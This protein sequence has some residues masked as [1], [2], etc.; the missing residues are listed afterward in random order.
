MSGARRPRVIRVD[1]N[2]KDVRKLYFIN[3]TT[4]TV[5][6]LCTIDLVYLYSDF[7][8]FFTKKYIYKFTA[9]F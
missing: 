3:F 2:R 8:F 6:V 1:E 4:F 5:T 7:F 9:I